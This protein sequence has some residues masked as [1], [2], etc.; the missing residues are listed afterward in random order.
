[1]IEKE[2]LI[3][4]RFKNLHESITK[5]IIFAS[6]VDNEDTPDEPVESFKRIINSK[7]VALAEQELN[8]QFESHGFSEVSFFAGI[9]GKHLLGKFALVQ[10]RL[11]KQSLPLF[12]GRSRTTQSRRAKEPPHNSP[13]RPNSRSRNDS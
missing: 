13:A 6:A 2:G 11:P 12:F 10:Q 8:T 3:K 1:M 4:N 9:H 7:T 5:M